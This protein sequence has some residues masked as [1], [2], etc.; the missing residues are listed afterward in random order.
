M[1]LSALDT[2]D[3]AK[4]ERGKTQA[5][6]Q[7][8]ALFL[9]KRVSQFRQAKGI[10]RSPRKFLHERCVMLPSRK[11][12]Q[13]RSHLYSHLTATT[14]P[15]QRP[16]SLANKATPPM[17]FVVDQGA[18][19]VK[20]LAAVAKGPQF[21]SDPP[22]NGPS[23]QDSTARIGSQT[24]TRASDLNVSRSKS[25]MARGSTKKTI[26]T[27]SNID[28]DFGDKC[29]RSF[30]QQVKAQIFVSYLLFLVHEHLPQYNIFFHHRAYSIAG[31]PASSP[32]L[33]PLCEY[34]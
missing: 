10:P 6:N 26:R 9:V 12:N 24:A 2:L 32:S 19:Y 15:L 23:T 14:C 28:V 21:G 7:G 16:R 18:E 27:P 1:D 11:V 34:N 8:Q 33:G 20:R 4:H 17:G 31:I 22:P 3:H 30:T 25:M 5:Y 29:T 13:A